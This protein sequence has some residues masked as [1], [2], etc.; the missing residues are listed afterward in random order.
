MYFWFRA[1]S[2]LPSTS[3]VSR[4][5]VIFLL[6][7]CVFMFGCL[8]WRPNKLLRI[9]TNEWTTRWLLSADV[10]DG[11]AT[12]SERAPADCLRGA[13]RRRLRAVPV[14]D[15]DD[16]RRRLW[17]ISPQIS[18][19]HAGRRDWWATVGIT[20]LQLVGRD[21]VH[22]EHLAR[23]NDLK[24]WRPIYRISYDLSPDYRKFIVRSTVTTVTY[25]VLGFLV[26]S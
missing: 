25:D 18:G 1:I 13:G 20:T 8:Y 5:V 14:D 15:D 9:N 21:A 23:D 22:F 26:V 11:V 12:S 2:C 16:V 7:N 10:C 24:T 17:K 6:C 19:A 4:S 3:I